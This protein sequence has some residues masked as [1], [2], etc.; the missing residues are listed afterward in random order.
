MINKFSILNGAKHF[1]PGIF[2]NYLVFIQAKKCIKYYIGTTS[3]NL[4]KSSGISE[5][6]IEN[7]TKSDSFFP[8]I[9]I[10][11]RVLR[12]INFNGHC[13]INNIYIPRKVINI[14][15]YYTLNP[16]SRNLNTVFTLNNC[17]FGSINLIK[18]ADSDKYKYSGYDIGFNS[19]SELSFRDG[20]MGK[21]SHL[22][23]LIIKI[24]IY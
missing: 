21:M 2:Q 11:H 18:N 22:C 17:L 4:W 24:R 1:S 3:V 6:N 5:E 19:R 10:D 8:P 9:F 7:I 16:L 14:Y 12:D 23:I 20:S 13:L 15:I